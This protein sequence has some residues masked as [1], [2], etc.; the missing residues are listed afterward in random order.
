M[1]EA[2]WLACADPK[3]MLRYLLGLRPDEGRVQDIV[4]FPACRS[5]DRKLRLFACACYHRIR[6]VLPDLCVKAAIDVAEQVA[7]GIIPAEELRRAEAIIRVPIGILEERWRAS[8]GMERIEIHPLHAALSLDLVIL[9]KEAQKAAYYA[10][11]NAYLDFAAIAN[12]G[13]SNHSLKYSASQRSE[14]RGQADLLRCMFGNIFR[15]TI[16]N[17]AWL[18]FDVQMI[19]AGAYEDRAFNRLPILADALQD[20]GCDNENILSHLRGDSPH[21]RGCWALDL[22][23]GKS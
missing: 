15:L 5:S 3:P 12:P 21:V 22:I 1:T 4:S 9:W 8:Q 17:S 13:A 23:L 20:A 19:A 2:E 7:D 10:S 11:S 16:I 18:T 14:E 6:H